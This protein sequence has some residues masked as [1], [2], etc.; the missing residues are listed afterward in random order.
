MNFFDE[1]TGTPTWTFRWIEDE[2]ASEKNT[3]QVIENQ[4]TDMPVYSADITG[5]APRPPT[6]IKFGVGDTARRRQKVSVTF[7][8]V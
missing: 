2:S 7:P 5:A 6:R 8:D 3:R 4:A 1:T